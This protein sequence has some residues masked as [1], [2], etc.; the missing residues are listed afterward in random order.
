MLDRHVL[1]LPS[2][3]TIHD[4]VRVQGRVRSFESTGRP[5]S[6]FE[7]VASS[8]AVKA[9]GGIATHRRS[10][11]CRGSVTMHAKLQNARMTSPFD[12]AAE[13]SKGK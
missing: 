6:E 7:H 3:E 10:G 12:F 5:P 8:L 4:P 2:V 13:F 1:S 9:E 11:L